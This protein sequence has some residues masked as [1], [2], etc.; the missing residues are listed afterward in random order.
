MVC[1]CFVCLRTY[2]FG[3]DYA[4]PQPPGYWAAEEQ[5][6]VWFRGGP[7]VDQVSLQAW[8]QLLWGA[9]DE[10]GSAAVSLRILVPM[11]MRAACGPAKHMQHAL[12]RERKI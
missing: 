9:S 5:S 10:D 7:E 8:Q 11:Q 3:A 4:Q 2:R 6:K 12:K 1:A